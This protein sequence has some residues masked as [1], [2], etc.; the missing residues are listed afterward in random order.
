MPVTKVFW[1]VMKM[2]ILWMLVVIVSQPAAAC[3]SISLR[4]FD[5]F[6]LVDHPD[7][8]VLHHIL[9]Q[10]SSSYPRY[11]STILTTETKNNGTYYIFMYE[12][13]NTHCERDIPGK[14]NGTFKLISFFLIKCRNCCYPVLWRIIVEYEGNFI[15][16]SHSADV[17]I[18][19]SNYPLPGL[20]KTKHSLHHSIQCHATTGKTT[21]NCDW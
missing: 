17:E 3:L 5:W 2:K 11:K 12:T 6:L 21:F 19:Q 14:T 9:D 15:K 1:W 13:V 18:T 4:Y 10:C 20:N 16:F 8:K 7:Y